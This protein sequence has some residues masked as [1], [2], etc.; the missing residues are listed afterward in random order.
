[1][2]NII[3]NNSNAT[4]VVESNALVRG[5]V[6][7]TLPE[8]RIFLGVIAQVNV[9]DDP[10][11]VY[12]IDLPQMLKDVNYKNKNVYAITKDASHSIQGKV[13]NLNLG[14][15]SEEE[16]NL[17]N[18]FYNIKYSTGTGKIKAIL[19]PQL[20]VH[21][22]ELKEN[23]TQYDLIQVFRISSAHSI[24]IY[25]LLKSHLWHRN[26]VEFSVE[27][28]KKMLVIEGKYTRFS[29]F[30]KDV[31]DRA[32]RH[33]T[34]NTDISF[35]Y[36]PSKRKGRTITHLTFTISE[37]TPTK[38]LA[39][40]IERNER[41]I[42]NSDYAL[43]AD[44]LLVENGVSG[45]RLAKIMKFCDSNFKYLYLKTIEVVARIDKSKKKID[46]VP[47]YITKALR[48]DYSISEVE[49]LFNK[50]SEKNAP[51]PQQG[52]EKNAAQ[53]KE[54]IN[55]QKLRDT[56]IENIEGI[57]LADEFVLF[58]DKYIEQYGEKHFVSVAL[59]NA[60]PE[61]YKD[62]NIVKMAFHG[63]I[64]K[65]HLPSKWHSLEEWEEE[66]KQDV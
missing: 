44:A 4:R 18:L 29:D 39:L 15:D 16:G 2:S 24:R 43:K 7:F 11:T 63:H 32:K 64:A 8:M 26:K 9:D 62:S 60:I 3:P 31:L 5:K 33:L 22:A 28:I 35:T 57:N 6:S 20:R 34:E 40:P 13:V 21:V 51:K 23:F 49:R 30:K 54:L 52:R 25:R 17:I 45:A 61:K 38:P 59:K 19:H 55:F 27:E 1:M 66:V 12:E 41:E 36:E 47:A 14:D 42:E 37:N 65:N 48:D 50:D 10:M 46:N 56:E 58:V 53:Q